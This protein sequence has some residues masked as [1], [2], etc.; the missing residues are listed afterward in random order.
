MKMKAMI[1]AAVAVLSMCWNGSSFAADQL[2]VHDFDLGE[3]P[4]ENAYD[5]GAWNKDPNDTTQGCTES[6]ETAERFGDKGMSLRLDYDVDSPAPAYNGMWMKL[7]ELD[8]S[9]YKFL[10]FYIKGDPQKGFSK[11]IKLELKNPNEVGKNLYTE[12]TGEWKL[13]KIPLS[14]FRGLKDL[15]KATEFVMVF[16][17]MNTKPKTGTIYVDNI[18]FSAE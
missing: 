16:D 15:T 5:F 17:D 18:F 10:N 9:K 14:E 11:V 6:F 12:V 2:L 3:K 13:A 7:K 8:L 4:S 1:L